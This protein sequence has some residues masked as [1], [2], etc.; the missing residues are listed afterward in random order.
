MLLLSGK[1]FYLSGGKTNNEVGN[2]R[3]FRFSGTVRD[4]G[5]P[6]GGLGQL[7]GFNGLGNS[8]NLVHLQQQAIARFLF[9]GNGNSF[10]IRHSQI[11]T[12]NLFNFVD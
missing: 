9:N 4:H 8:S 11:V 3:V 12:N 10:G 7:M 1:R 6:T 2:E 5:A